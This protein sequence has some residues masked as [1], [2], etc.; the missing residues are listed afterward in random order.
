MFDF[1][2]IFGLLDPDRTTTLNDNGVTETSFKLFAMYKTEVNG[3]PQLIEKSVAT[4]TG[5]LYTGEAAKRVCFCQLVPEP[6]TE[7]D[8]AAFVFTMS[9]HTDVF[10][11]EIYWVIQMIIERVYGVMPKRVIDLTSHYREVAKEE[12]DR[13]RFEM[14]MAYGC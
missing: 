2:R 4:V 12:E 1:S 6:V 14:A 9:T 5:T 3:I 10:E 8:E 13:R 7:Q 11:E